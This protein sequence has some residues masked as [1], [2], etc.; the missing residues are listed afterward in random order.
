M[1][2]AKKVVVW[3]DSVARGVIY[4]EKRNRY[5]LARTSAAGIVAEKLNIE[6]F[7]QDYTIVRNHNFLHWK[8]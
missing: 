8:F 5:T 6:I 7:L 1:L 4:D 2:Y 3:G